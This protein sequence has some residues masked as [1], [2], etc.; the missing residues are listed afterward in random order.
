[1][2][3]EYQAFERQLKEDEG[4]RDRPYVDTTGNVTIG[5]GHNL[6]A[7]GLPYDWYQ[8]LFEIGVERAGDDVVAW[9]GAR[10]YLLSYPRMAALMNMAFN[11]GLPRLRT[12]VKL[13]QAILDQDWDRAADEML[14][15]KWARQVGARAERLAEEM[16]R[17]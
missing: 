2:S 16:R 9:L 8:E 12:F 3:T 4:F 5:W 11:L 17:G 10:A 13:R 6:T 15:S 7:N 1:M 14:D